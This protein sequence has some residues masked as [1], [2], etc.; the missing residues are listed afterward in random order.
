MLSMG[1]A[2]SFRNLRRTAEVPKDDDWLTATQQ[3]RNK[4]ELDSRT[5]PPSTLLSHPLVKPHTEAPAFNV[6]ATRS[7]G[8]L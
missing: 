4:A 6:M 1:T 5:L 7:R 3:G 2:G 8:N